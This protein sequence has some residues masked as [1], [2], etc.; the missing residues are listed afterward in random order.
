MAF[1]MVGYFNIYGCKNTED[2]E[3]YTVTFAIG[4]ACD[5]SELPK[6]PD[7]GEHDQ[8]EFIETQFLE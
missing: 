7:C 1:K 6:C 3:N 2:H 4:Q 8:V 5:Q